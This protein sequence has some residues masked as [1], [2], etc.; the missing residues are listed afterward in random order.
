MSQQ[1][2]DFAREK[3][4]RAAAR[5]AKNADR[6]Y[7][8]WSDRA[9]ELVGHY[10]R[11]IDRPF[12]MEEARKHAILAGLSE[13]SEPRAWGGVTNRCVR[14]GVIVFT[15]H[16]RPAISSNGTAKKEWRAK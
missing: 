8:N 2:L 10:A 5:A 15:G 7:P 11:I 12:L 6:E 13:P 16:Y 1:Q 9:V 4:H 14:E 3:S